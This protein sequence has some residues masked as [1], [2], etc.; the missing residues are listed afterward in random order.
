MAEESFFQVEK[1]VKL[2]RE[3]KMGKREDYIDKLAAQLKVWSAPQRQYL[4]RERGR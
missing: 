1:A 2:I 4:D 3:G